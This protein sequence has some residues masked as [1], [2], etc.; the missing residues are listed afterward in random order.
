MVNVIVTH[1]SF[2]KWMGQWSFVRCMYGDKVRIDNRTIWS[3]TNRNY[4]RALQ[5]EQFQSMKWAR[6]KLTKRPTKSNFKGA[7]NKNKA[8]QDRHIVSH[9]QKKNIANNCHWI[10]YETCIDIRKTLSITINEMHIKIS[11]YWLMINSTGFSLYRIS[12]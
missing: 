10:I 6:E 9:Y 1:L 3:L 11:L 5:N 8:S 7:N 12:L 2:R 4:R